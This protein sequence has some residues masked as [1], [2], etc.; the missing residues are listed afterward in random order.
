MLSVRGEPMPPTPQTALQYQC[1]TSFSS[2]VGS[3]IALFNY[4]ENQGLSFLSC[5]MSMKY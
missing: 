5:K 2:C 3:K 4:G 1:V